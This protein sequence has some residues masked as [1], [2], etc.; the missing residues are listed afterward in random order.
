[1]GL[2]FLILRVPKLKGDG[3][4]PDTAQ[5]DIGPVQLKDSR[6]TADG[7][8]KVLVERTVYGGVP[9]A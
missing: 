8:S 1:M 5:T 2:I 7:L 3:K 6:V 9:E 4:I